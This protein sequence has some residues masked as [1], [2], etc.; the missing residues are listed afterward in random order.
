[1]LSRDRKVGERCR[2]GP[3][4]LETRVWGEV[5]PRLLIGKREGRRKTPEHKRNP[6]QDRQ[7]GHK[8]RGGWG[9][10]GRRSKKC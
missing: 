2:V 10:G 6:A 3:K 9:K 4:G 1:M 8:G 5:C 7:R